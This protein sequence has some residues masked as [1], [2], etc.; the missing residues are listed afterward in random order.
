MLNVRRLAA[1]DVAFLGPAI[2]IAEFAVGVIGP[3]A[4]GI[5]IASRSH[6]VNQ[7][8]LAAYFVALGINYFPLLLHA[9][10]LRDHSRARLEIESELGS[11][12]RAAMRRYRRGSLLLL[13]PLVIPFLAVMQARGRNIPA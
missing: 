13:L 1:I 4:L 9:L 2:I 5:F 12:P 10:S 3:L 7:A 11:D 6:S 8:M